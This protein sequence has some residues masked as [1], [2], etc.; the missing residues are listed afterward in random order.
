MIIFYTFAP[1]KTLWLKRKMRRF[2]LVLTTIVVLFLTAPSA[3]ADEWFNVSSLGGETIA[4]NLKITP[5]DDGKSYLV[6]VR[7]SFDVPESRAAYTRDRGYDKTVAYKL[8]L[9]KF[10]NDWKSFNIVQVTVYGENG[11]Q[12]DQY[13]NTSASTTMI[14]IYDDSSIKPVAEAAKVVYEITT[15]PE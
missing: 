14:P 15:N 11:E 5:S 10:S 6:W 1:L 4:L 2:F 9:Y 13:A 3:L 7:N 12:I 8:S